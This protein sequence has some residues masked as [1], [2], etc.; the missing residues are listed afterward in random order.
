MEHDVAQESQIRFTS[1]MLMIPRNR[2]GEYRRAVLE[3]L[4]VRSNFP[5]FTA[6]GRGSELTCR[7]WMR[8]TETS[9]EYR[10]EVQYAANE[11]PDVRILE[12]DIAVNV[13]LHMYGRGTLCLYDWRDQPW[14]NAWHL[15]QTVIPWTAE[16]LVFYELF[17]LTGKWLGHSAIHNGKTAGV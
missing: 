5:F 6:R 7:G 4:L 13:A 12:P 10:V 2:A 15:H 9:E 16:W 1:F 14:Q 3:S 11:A 17:L 8:P